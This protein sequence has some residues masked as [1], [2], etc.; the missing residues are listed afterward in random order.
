MSE[1]EYGATYQEIV[2]ECEK[3]GISISKLCRKADVDRMVLQ[4]WKNGDPKSIQILNAL[5]E[6]IKQLK[7]EKA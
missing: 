4:R 5:R 6:S 3:L 7:K 1:E 2:N